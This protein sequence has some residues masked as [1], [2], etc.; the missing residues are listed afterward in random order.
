[1]KRQKFIVSF[2]LRGKPSAQ[3]TFAKRTAAIV[4]T[5]TTTYADPNQAMGKKLGTNPAEIRANARA[6]AEATGALMQEQMITMV[7]AALLVRQREAAQAVVSRASPAAG[8][9]PVDVDMQRMEIDIV[10]VT[11]ALKWPPFDGV[12]LEECGLPADAIIRW[13][14]MEP[15]KLIR[16]YKI[17]RQQYIDGVFQS[18]VSDKYSDPGWKDADCVNEEQPGTGRNDRVWGNF[19]RFILDE[20]GL[21][22]F[23]P[24]EVSEVMGFALR[25]PRVLAKGYTR[26][27]KWMSKLLRHSGNKVKKARMKRHRWK[28]TGFGLPM[29][30]VAWFVWGDVTEAC[31]EV[32]LPEEKA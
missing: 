32:L 16:D 8:A 25:S 15:G 12:P 9:V 22:M 21:C 1:M 2:G 18:N 6:A 7:R 28:D 23:T 30:S 11:Q 26:Q 3:S 13:D 17:T 19:S 31:R 20:T 29:D 5:P 24:D 14:E 10:G 4:T 27:A